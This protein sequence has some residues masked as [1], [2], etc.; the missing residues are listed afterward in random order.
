MRPI[1]LEITFSGPEGNTFQSRAFTDDGKKYIFRAAF[2][3]AGKWTWQSFCSDAGDKGLH[4]KRGKVRVAPYTGENP[5][6]KHG[7]LAVSYNNRYLI[8]ADG[9]PFL[10]MGETGWCASI[11]STMKE[12]QDYIDTRA[13]Q[14]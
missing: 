4:K 6:Y 11:K 3:A 13:G 5:L 10:W 2:P 8:H 7:D 9:T 14:H 12:W 1:S